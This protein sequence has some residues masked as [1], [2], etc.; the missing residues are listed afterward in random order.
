MNLQQIAAQQLRDFDN[1]DPGTVFDTGLSFDTAE[2]VVRLKWVDLQNLRLTS[3]RSRV[4]AIAPEQR[5]G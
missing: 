1:H 4:D 2:G 5:Y 3:L